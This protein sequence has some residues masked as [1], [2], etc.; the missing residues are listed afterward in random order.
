MLEMVMAQLIHQIKPTVLIGSSSVANAFNQDVI[1]AM[2]KHTARPIIMPLSNP[3][4]YAE[5]QPQDIFNWTEGKALVATGSPF[6]KVNYKNQTITI[7]QCNNSFIFPGIGLGVIASKASRLTEGMLSAASIALSEHAPILK[8][9]YGALLPK[10]TDSRQVAKDIAIAV[11]KKAIAE[12]IAFAME[13]TIAT[14]IEQM[15]WYPKY[16]AMRPKA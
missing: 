12:G 15:M 11:A 7:A 6:P 5:A 4:A 3:T 9:P 14:D 16:L 2:A 1:Q 10:L 8:E 13:D